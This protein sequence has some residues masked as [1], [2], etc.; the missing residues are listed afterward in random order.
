VILCHQVLR[1]KA[2]LLYKC[3]CSLGEGAFW[4]E[5]RQS[6]FWLDID[7]KRLFEYVSPKEKVNTWRFDHRPSFIA[8]DTQGQFVIAFQGGIAR[9]DLKTGNL[10]WLVDIEKN[11][12]EQRTNDGAIDSEGRLWIGTMNVQFKEGAGALYC[13]NN[14]LLLIKKIEGLTIPNGLVWSLDDCTMYHI[15]SPTRKVQSYSF[16]HKS[17]T[18]VFEKTAITIPQE[19]GTPDG[20]CIDEEGMLWIAQWNGF[21]VYR[22]D[23]VNGKLLEKIEVPVPQ[24]SNCAFGGPNFDQLFITTARENFSMESLKKYPDSGSVYIAQPGVRGVRKNLFRK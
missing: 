23:P 8:L 9:F 18:I 24:V 17:G 4:H 5:A 21:G 15:D 13:L 10:Q 7:G 3:D 14:K 12:T 19:A 6:F 20:M 22:W 16:D 2:S 1:M 11:N